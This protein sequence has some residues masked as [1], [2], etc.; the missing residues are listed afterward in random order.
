MTTPFTPPQPDDGPGGPTPPDVPVPAAGWGAAPQY[1]GPGSAPAD[2][3]FAPPAAPGG[4]ASSGSASAGPATGGPA[5]GGPATGGPAPQPEYGQYAPTPPAPSGP[6]AGQPYPS[7]GPYPTEYGQ[8]PASSGQ[9]P[10]GY[11]QYPPPQGQHYGAPY[12]GYGPGP[13]FYTPPALKPGIIPLRPL[14]LGEIWDGAF[15]SIR[16]SPTVMFGL[17]AVVMLLLEILSVAL[18]F[19]AFGPSMMTFNFDD[20]T[21]NASM[22]ST[23]LVNQ[24]TR[25]LGSSSVMVL[26]NLMAT[27]ILTGM[28]TWAVSRAVIGQRVTIKQTWHAISHRVPAMVGLGLLLTLIPAAA[29]VLGFAVPAVLAAGTLGNSGHSGA[30]QAVVVLLALALVAGGGILAGFFFVRLL[31]APAALILEDASI[32]T[33]IKRSWRLTKGSFWR[34]TGIYLLTALV[35]SLASGTIASVVG[36]GG[37]L[38]MMLSPWLGAV[39]L[40]LGSTIASTLVTPFTAA[41]TALLYIDRRMRSEG[42]DIELARAAEA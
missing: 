32:G 30:A 5:A 35:A 29:M 25:M 27:T 17:T 10:P 13:G 41:V 9:Y 8:Y 37:A 40:V 14:R 6:A 4:A 20:G 15:R 11:G 3:Q 24:L 16:Y 19:W 22:S 36:L 31:L 21:A 26:V 23:D 38:S 42:L 12:P 7:A 33:A 28:L 2:G 39:L 34:I 18:T 1:T